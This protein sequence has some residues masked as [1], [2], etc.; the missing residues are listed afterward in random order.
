MLKEEERK[1]DSLI[2]RRVSLHASFMFNGSKLKNYLSYVRKIYTRRRF[3]NCYHKWFLSAINYC[4][5]GN[6]FM[7]NSNLIN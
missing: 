6:F 5:A 2:L 7:N 4:L 1:G 3:N